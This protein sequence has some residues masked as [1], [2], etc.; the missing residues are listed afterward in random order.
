M[1]VSSTHL[2][3]CDTT[4]SYDSC[5]GTISFAYDGASLATQTAMI[6]AVKGTKE[7]DT[8]SNRGTCDIE[9]GLC[10]CFVDG[11]NDIPTFHFVPT[12]NGGDCGAV[13]G[14]IAS[15]TGV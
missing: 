13:H 2:S 6:T 1:Y 12:M 9:T 8:C 4:E 15:S 5:G 7:A 14:T 11:E 3:G 10:T